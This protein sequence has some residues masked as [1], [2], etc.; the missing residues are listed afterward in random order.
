[1][2]TALV[3]DDLV[4]AGGAERVVVALNGMFPQAPI[5]TSVYDRRSTL[6]EFAKADV[7]TSFLQKTPFAHRRFHKL[8]L[9]LFPSAFEQ[10]DLAGYDLV[11]SNTTRF[12]KG[13]IT[14]PET[15]HVC[16]CH[17]P[18][19]FAWRPQDYLA[20]SRSARLLA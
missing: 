5:Y 17:T 18:P 10:F 11:L 6:A 1:M 16:Y 8:A 12:A 7:R 3:H 2:K 19:R 4:Q 14:A 15:C 13:V 9:P 20:Q